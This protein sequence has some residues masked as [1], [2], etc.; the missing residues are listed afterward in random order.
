MN[1]WSKYS[2]EKPFLGAPESDWSPL[3]I[4]NQMNQNQKKIS[5]VTYP[6]GNTNMVAQVF[7]PDFFWTKTLKETNGIKLTTFTKRIQ[8]ALR[9]SKVC[10]KKIVG[11]SEHYYDANANIHKLGII[12]IIE[13]NL[14]KKMNE[15]Q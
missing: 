15:I 12:C 5:H 3:I 9:N 8:Y 13:E 10:L 2:F 11:Q 6:V 7:C 4:V 1:F 14:K